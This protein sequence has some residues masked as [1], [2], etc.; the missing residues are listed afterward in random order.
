MPLLGTSIDSLAKVNLQNGLSTVTVMPR[1]RI[2]FVVT[3]LLNQD[4]RFLAGFTLFLSACQNG[5]RR[6]LISWI[7]LVLSVEKNVSAQK[8]DLRSKCRE[9]LRINHLELYNTRKIVE[10]CRSEEQQFKALVLAHAFFLPVGAPICHPASD[11]KYGRCKVS[12]WM[13]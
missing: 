9:L 3:V 10:F 8:K 2:S 1:I 13:C 5:C 12:H 11:D 7:V 4:A 6:F